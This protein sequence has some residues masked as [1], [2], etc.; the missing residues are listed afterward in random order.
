MNGLMSIGPLMVQRLIAN[1]RLL[2]VLAFGVLVA[3][4]LLA[5]SPVYTRVMNDLGLQQSLEKTL[6][7]SSRNGFTMV[8]IPLGDPAVV[9]QQQ[10][11]ARAMSEEIGWFT[12]DE[13]RF[14]S[15]PLMTLARGGKLVTTPDEPVLIRVQGITR[16]EDHVNFVSGRAA[17]PT[18]DPTKLEVVIPGETAAFLDADLG[19]TVEATFAYDDCNRPPA[20]QDPDQI[21]ELQRFRCTPQTVVNVRITAVIVG[22]IERRD[23]DDPFWSTGSINFNRPMATDE[24][25]AIVPAVLPE[26]SFFQALPQQLPSFPSEFRLLGLIDISRLDSANLDEAQA[27]LARLKKRIED[28]G[29]IPDLATASPLAS[30]QNRASFNQVTLILLLIQ[31]VGIA[32][33]YV[34]LVSTLL[35]ERRSEEIAMLR[36]RGATVGQLVAMS[37]AEAFALGL[38]AAF[39][40]PFLASG[41]IA[42]LGKTGTF[43]SIS[44]GG[45]LP[46][47]LVPVAFL[48]AL[49]GAAIAAIAVV[50][51]AFIAAKKGMVLFLRS[52]ARP[53]KSILQRYYLDFALVGISAFSLWQLNQ[54]GSVFDPE[55]VGG[56][57]ADP[58][59]L[60]SPLLIILAIGALLFRFLPLV[61]GLITRIATTTAGPGITLGLWQLTRSPARYTQ[62]AL[63]VVMAAAVGTFAATYGETTDRSQQDRALYSSGSDMRLTGIGQLASG[64]SADAADKLREVPGVE[65]AMTATRTLMSIGPLPNFGAQVDILGVE[66]GAAGDIAWWRDDFANQ[67]LSSML[68]RIQGSPIR[69]HGI[70]LP[71]EPAAVS[72]WVAPVGPRQGT[73]LWLRTVDARGVFRFHEFGLLNFNGYRRMEARLNAQALGAVYPLSVVGI[74]MTQTESVN[75]DSRTLI[76][77]DLGVVSASG[78]ETII[79]DFESAFRWEVV[80]T[81]TR[82]RDT[83]THVNQNAHS[84]NGAAAFAFLTGTGVPIRGMS[85]SDPNIPVPALASS[86][87]MER[88]GLKIG[89]E[90]ELVFG[91]LLMPVTIQ[92]VV[93]YFPTMYNND[94]GYIIVNQ[95]HLFY[96][97]GMTSERATQSTPTEAWLTLTKDPQAREEAQAA[98][99][100]RYGIPAGQII[101]SQLI[102]EEIRTDPVVRAG[103]SGILLVALIAAFAILAL[104]FALTLYLGGQARTVEVSVM[105]AVGISPR[106]LLTMISLEYL[107]IAAI[108]LIIGTIAG[109]R[110]SETMLGF[111]NVTDDGSKVIPGFALVTRWDTVAIAFGAVGVAFLAGVLALAVYFL[112]LPV[113]RVIRLTR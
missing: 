4:T 51:P 23:V 26:E 53:G 38:A 69:D 56:W 47:T 85:V 90:V 57:S 13:V 49:G 75:E 68:R 46:F 101:D 110:I 61:L 60:M 104:G 29:A 91:K 40:A 65:N 42:L 43:E 7:S 97:A 27:S 64:F 72:L 28:A 107:M 108:G 83:L 103:G 59:L 112:R 36:S 30:F 37:V 34:M 5:I 77:D 32:V 41:A 21:R 50:V 20:T 99:L 113:S 71:G 44:G 6:R 39:V 12:K 31:V 16:I 82:D 10:E 8:P 9:R 3:S 84:G 54:R 33:Y 86:Y 67:D 92:G 100:D 80:R 106:Q 105:R 14:G 22:I 96:Y 88:T 102:L 2:L 74:F 109:L 79:D 89:G 18:N 25:P 15:L 87:F 78:Q 94:A 55:S 35:A 45:F 81:A 70:Q 76:I 48:F 98:F 24:S 95:D 19:E 73:T 52:S 58:L 11:L 93:D 1:W 111:L 17:Q 63:L 62:L 66:P